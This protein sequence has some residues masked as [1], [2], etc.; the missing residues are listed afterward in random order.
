MSVI[1]HVFQ[2]PRVTEIRPAPPA[3][4]IGSAGS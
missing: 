4:P 2:S 1:S 3:H